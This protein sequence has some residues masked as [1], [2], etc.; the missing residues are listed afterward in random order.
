[1]LVPMDSPL[2]GRYLPQDYTRVR[3]ADHILGATVFVRREL[4]E[5]MGGMDEKFAL[6]F[7]ETDWCYRAKK[8][9]WKI[10]YTPDAA[11]IHLGAHSTSKNPEL[12][13]V[14]FYRTQ[15]YFYRKNYGVFKYIALKIITVFGLA[16]WLARTLKGWMT[17][18][19]DAEK[20]R[21]RVWSYW[22]IL[23]A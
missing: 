15:S 8:A 16:F 9:G 13:S 6:Y 11:I 5:K 22:E 12:S 1:M 20:L 3:D 7:E 23:K 19:I 10:L 18:K 4:Y 2:N 17:K 21:M 14:R